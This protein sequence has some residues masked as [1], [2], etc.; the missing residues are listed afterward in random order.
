LSWTTLVV[1]LVVPRRFAKDSV[2]H[3]QPLA[4]LEDARRSLWRNV[5]ELQASRPSRSS[6]HTTSRFLHIP[7]VDGCNATL[8]SRL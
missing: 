6:Y 2:W 8:N 4:T 1:R 5:G 3:P 7:T